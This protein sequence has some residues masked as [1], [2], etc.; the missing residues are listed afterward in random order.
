MNRELVA[1]VIHDLKNSLG[2]LT[3]GLHA[4][5]EHAAGT[6][7]EA[8][9]RDSYAIAAR[10]SQ[11]L[12]SFLTLY[13][14]GDGGLKVQ[15]LDHS[16]EDFLRDLAAEL[17]LLPAAPRVKVELME[18]VAPFW[19]Y[20]AYFVRL[21]IEAAVQNATRFA[22]SA[23]TLSARMCDDFLVFRVADDGPGLGA[24]GAPSTGLGS[25]LCTAIAEAHRNGN[26]VGKVVLQNGSERGAVFEL[27][28]P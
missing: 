2:V 23:I 28:L 8:E 9:A 14:T 15:P 27:W 4:M 16:P 10:L 26:R 21:A 11:N 7:I 13:R 20:D 22:R 1:A 24:A 17:V 6:G 12:V 18:P 3:G 19:F 25:A 5:A